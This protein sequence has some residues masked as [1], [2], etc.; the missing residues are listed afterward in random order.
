MISPGARRRAFEIVLAQGADA[1][2]ALDRSALWNAA[3]Q[4]EN[5]RDARVAREFEIALPHELNA[6]QRV[7]LT[8][9]FAQ[10]L[11]DR[12]GT[13]VDFAIHAPHGETDGR[14]FHAH[15]MMT[16]RAVNSE[17]LA[18]RRRSSERTNGLRLIICR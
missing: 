16:T 7:E 2:W 18:T 3:E 14:N 10:G 15:L 4:S 8:R 9:E 5:R 1:E 12:H 11:A 6:E 13:A 17:G